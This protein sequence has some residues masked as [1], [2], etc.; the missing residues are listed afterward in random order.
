MH[1][2]RWD[3]HLGCGV[4]RGVSLVAPGKLGMSSLNGSGCT[5]KNWMLMPEMP[6]PRLFPHENSCY[7]SIFNRKS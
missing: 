7:S 5:K 1:L 6:E 4:S 2:T 3:V